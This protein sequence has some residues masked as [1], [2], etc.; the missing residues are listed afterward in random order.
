MKSTFNPG[1]TCDDVSKRRVNRYT[2]L[3]ITSWLQI[4]GARA[5]NKLASVNQVKYDTRGFKRFNFMH[6]SLLHN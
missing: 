3:Y 5:M 1:Q 6:K 4:I 2:V